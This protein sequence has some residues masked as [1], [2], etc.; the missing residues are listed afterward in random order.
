MRM[1]ANDIEQRRSATNE[2]PR[3]V[4]LETSAAARLMG[5]SPP[6]RTPGLPA[7]AGAALPCCLKP[8]TR[9]RT[10]DVFASSA[11]TRLKAIPGPQSTAISN[12]QIPRLE[13]DLTL[14][15]SMSM[16]LLIAKNLT[17]PISALSTVTE[18]RQR[19]LKSASH[20]VYLSRYVSKRPSAI[21]ARRARAT[22][23][24]QTADAES[25]RRKTGT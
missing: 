6:W 3:V 17:I 25:N 8:R 11:R 16:S 14:A 18:A 7:L 5:Q 13:L 24:K 9:S 12:S 2:D 21:H 20:Y 10:A 4:F 1:T 19:H 23:C 22:H 15:K